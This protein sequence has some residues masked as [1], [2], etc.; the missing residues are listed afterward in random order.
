MSIILDA[1]RRGREGQAPAPNPNPSQTDAV[2]Q[3]LGYARLQ[4]TTPLQRM[5]RV[6]G[7]LVLA[8]V[9]VVLIWASVT[10]F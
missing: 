5:K 3:T 10:R 9:L 1:L 6:L 2:L 7:Y 8:A 4:R